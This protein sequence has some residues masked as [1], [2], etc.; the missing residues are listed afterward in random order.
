M[1]PIL[2]LGSYVTINSMKYPEYFFSVDHYPEARRE[3]YKEVSLSRAPYR[4]L[5]AGKNGG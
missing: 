5:P 4:K 3:K 2:G 1:D